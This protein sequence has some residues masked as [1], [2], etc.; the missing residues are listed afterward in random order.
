MSRPSE[1]AQGPRKGMPR[2]NWAGNHTYPFRLLRPE[3]TDDL[4]R[5]VMAE[6]TLRVLGSRHSFN[7]MVDGAVAVTLAGLPEDIVVDQEVSTVS[8]SGATT[9]GALA[10]AL[11]PHGLALHNLASLPHICVAGA[12]ATGTHG[13]GDGNGNLAT[14]VAGVEMLTASGDLVS[15]RRGHQDF[16]G[17]VVSLG[18]LGVVTRVTLDVE[19]A[20]GVAQR[21]YPAVAWDL[22]T[23]SFDEV[24][25]AGYSVSAFTD[26]SDRGANVWLKSRDVGPPTE[27]L[28]VPSA[29]G[30]SHVLPGVDA[31]HCTPQRG[32]WG[33]WAERLPHFR[34]GFTP[35]SG[36]EIQSEYHLPRQ[37]ALAA[38][39][40]LRDLHDVMQPVLLISEIRT[41]RGDDL[42]LSPHFG[43]DSVSFHFTWGPDQ[44]AVEVVVAAVETALAAYSPRAH[45]GKLFL[46]SP[47]DYPRLD[48]FVALKQRLDPGEKFSNDWLNTQLSRVDIQ[49]GF[50]EDATRWGVNP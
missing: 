49:G 14:A 4:R 30:D 50:R 29:E 20:Y 40:A 18:A 27:L 17:A 34:M 45:W 3:S 46:G 9:Y 48:D 7:A 47:G 28:G 21:V 12:I 1:R 16:V 37:H 15:L 26:W 13:S 24:F 43:R 2:K 44:A 11:A 10:L 41:V 42:W 8:C 25:A 38:I 32:V 33:P 22:L 39:S 23:P 31:V 6:P 19:P 36:D 35:S 5:V